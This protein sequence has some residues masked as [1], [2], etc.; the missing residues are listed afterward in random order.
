MTNCNKCKIIIT[1][2]GPYLVSGNVPIKEMII[3]SGKNGNEYI[4][5]KAILKR[6]IMHYVAVGIQKIC[7]FVMVSILQH[8]LM[9]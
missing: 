6:S 2:N 9:D 4:D 7:L 1:K 8:I 5:G 3:I